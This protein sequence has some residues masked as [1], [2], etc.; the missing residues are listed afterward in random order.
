MLFTK[1][2]WIGRAL[3]MAAGPDLVA[4]FLKT[5]LKEEKVFFISS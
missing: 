3:G 5:K 2:H 1:Y 4:F